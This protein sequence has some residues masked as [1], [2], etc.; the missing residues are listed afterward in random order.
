M[1]FIAK[2]PLM[3]PEV[4]SVPSVPHDGTRGLFASQDGWYDVDSSNNTKK[5][6]TYEDVI[7]LIEKN[8][9]AGSLVGEGEPTIF[10]EAS[11]G[12]LYIDTRDGGMAYVCVSIDYSEFSGDPM[13]YIWQPIITVD[14]DV[15]FSSKNPVSGRAVFTELSNRDQKIENLEIQVGDFEAALD[16]TIALCDNYIGGVVE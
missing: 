12:M 7:A 1:A 10:T 11:V 8:G 5:I 16:A 6:A 9:G 3:I 13:G 15:S 14:D 4:E 2:N